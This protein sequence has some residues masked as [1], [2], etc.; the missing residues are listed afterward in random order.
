MNEPPEAATLSADLRILAAAEHLFA[1][2]GFDGTS[3][4]ALADAAGVNRALIFYYFRSKEGLYRRLIEG[5]CE[6]FA[7]RV[8]EALRDAA[9]PVERLVSW[10]R[11]TCEEMAARPDVLRLVLREIVGPTP[12]SLPIRDYTADVE[13]PIR[14]IIEIGCR[15]GIFRPEVDPAMTAISLFGILTAYFRRR[16][17]TGEEFAAESVAEHVLSLVMDGL[18]Q[19]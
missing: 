5:A 13:A 8:A 17:V 14:D 12:S 6:E 2:Q 18:L 16:F 9:T 15:E 4:Q 7:G 19:R 1:T 3:I 11:V 10:V